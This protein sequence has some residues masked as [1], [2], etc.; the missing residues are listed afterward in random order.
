[1]ND[2][3]TIKTIFL[4]IFTVIFNGCNYLDVVPDNVTT[5]DNAFT[6]RYAAEKYLFTCYRYLPGHASY[7]ENPGFLA[8]DE[9]WTYRGTTSESTSGAFQVAQGY[10]NVNSPYVNYWDGMSQPYRGIRDCNIFLANIE[11]VPDMTSVERARWIA[12]VKF[13]KAY[14]HF[15]LLRMYGPIP[16]IRENLSISAGPEK[17]KVKREPVDDVVDYIIELLDEAMPDLPESIS[18][19][20]TELGRIDK[21]IAMSI[22][23]QILVTA[24]SPL[25]NGNPDY[26]GFVD[27]DGIPLFNLEYVG[28]KWEWAAEACREAIE[29]C[30][31][32]GKEL[33]YF[34]PGPG[35][36][37]SSEET[38]FQMNVRNAV[39][40]KWNPEII[41]GNTNSMALVLQ[42][43]CTPGGL[44]P[45]MGANQN[46]RGTFAPPIK[47]AEL[48]YSK[49]GVPISEDKNYNYSE[50][51]DLRVAT[52]D[53]KYHL[54]P[55]YTTVGL[56]FDRESRFYTSLAFDGG[57]WYGQGKTDDNDQWVLQSKS[58]QYQAAVAL[59]RYS[60][61]GYR[62]KKLVHHLNIIGTSSYT[63]QQYP[64]PVMRLADLYLL[65]AEALNEA[66]GPSAEALYWIDLVRERSGL[67][68]VEESWTQHSTNPDKYNTKEGLREI[69]QQERMI[70]LAFEGKRFWD[71]RRWK[72][73]H[74]ELNQPI[75][76]WDIDQE[77]EEGYYRQRTIHQQTFLV[78]DYLWPISENNLT[79]NSNLVQ[80]PGW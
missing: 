17:V 75:T 62:P 31:E 49:N 10:Q 39:T 69:I 65:Y 48:F 28:E 66:G 29:F 59:T 26:I 41:W 74:I 7:T 33:Y 19:E 73:A 8:G 46:T 36:Q 35:Y 70:E 15:W 1:M 80:N 25:F 55:G 47:M 57:I 40:E 14:Y 37:I 3:K 24:A 58:G 2:M 6:M 71:L 63:I 60:A 22:K 21:S 11:K 76:G 54:Q 13:L 53:E 78:R 56:H 20:L 42:R 79:I 43:V 9:I 38:I 51:F 45:A 52:E 67:R 34:Q 44:D 18:D 27:N 4:I 77:T 5:I 61:T 23:A 16:V 12:E 68:S 32:A 64:W 50:R 72:R 30:H